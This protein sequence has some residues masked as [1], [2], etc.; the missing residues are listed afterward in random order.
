[1]RV[2]HPAGEEQ[3]PGLFLSGQ[4]AVAGREGS[5]GGQ[6]QGGWHRMLP[7]P[8]LGLDGPHLQVHSDSVWFDCHMLELLGT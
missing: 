1:M 6:G 8:V 4:Q 7:L 2:L 5:H 3:C